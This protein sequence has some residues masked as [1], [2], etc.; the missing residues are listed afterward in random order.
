MGDRSR[1][2]GLFY[3]SCIDTTSVKWNHMSNGYCCHDK[4][5]G[6]FCNEPICCWHLLSHHGWRVTCLKLPNLQKCK[7]QKP[8]AWEG[9]IKMKE[10]KLENSPFKL[11]RL[12]FVWLWLRCDRPANHCN[13]LLG[14]AH[15]VLISSITSFSELLPW[16]FCP[17]LKTN[18][19]SGRLLV[20]SNKPWLSM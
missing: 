11:L 5:L 6:A 18:T 19:N 3:I 17:L 4:N 1:E 8:P 12:S 15:F 20:N 7:R 9:I 10:D 2:N 13:P 16:N 14:W